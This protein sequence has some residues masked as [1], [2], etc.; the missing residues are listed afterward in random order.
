MTRI[1]RLLSLVAILAFAIPA[2]GAAQGGAPE[3]KGHTKSHHVSQRCKKQPRVGYNVHGTLDPSSKR[4]A[5]VVNV[6]KANKHL[7]LFLDGGQ[8]T[9]NATDSAKAKF[10][11]A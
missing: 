8:L 9:L 3:G 10:H 11:G 1:A 2:V 5:V 4:D 7:K 6:K